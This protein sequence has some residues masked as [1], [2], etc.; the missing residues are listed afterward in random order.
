MNLSTICNRQLYN[1][2]NKAKRCEALAKR[3]DNQAIFRAK[4]KLKATSEWVDAT[5]VE[6]QCMEEQVKQD[7]INKRYYSV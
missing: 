7:I 2:S 3:A 1:T 6:C 5:L 4:Q